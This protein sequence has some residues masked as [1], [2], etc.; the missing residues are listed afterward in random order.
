MVAGRIV[1][2]TGRGASTGGGGGRTNCDGIITLRG[3]CGGSLGV[4]SGCNESPSDEWLSSAPKGG[5]WGGKGGGR[6]CA[7]GK[8]PVEGGGM[9]IADMGFTWRLA[10]P[11]VAIGISGRVGSGGGGGGFGLVSAAGG[12]A[13]ERGEKLAGRVW[14]L[15][16]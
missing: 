16:E 8:K 1:E 13:E 14:P 3:A 4:G 15:G 10:L 5:G 7:I 2:S 11:L 9:G 12:R 6:G